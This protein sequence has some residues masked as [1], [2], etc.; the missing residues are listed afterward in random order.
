MSRYEL[1]VRLVREMGRY[2]EI[3]GDTVQEMYQEI[4]RDMARYGEMWEICV[5]VGGELRRVVEG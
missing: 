3:W 2:D 1:D 4:W 5:A